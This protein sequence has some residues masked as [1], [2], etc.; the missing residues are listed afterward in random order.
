MPVQ[1]TQRDVFDRTG[2]GLQ[3][4]AVDDLGR[5]GTARLGTPGE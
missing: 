4:R 1:A 2:G 5:A 3:H